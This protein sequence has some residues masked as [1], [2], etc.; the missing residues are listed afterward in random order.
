MP[1]NYGRPT[2]LVAA[3]SLEG[4]G[5]AMT[6]EGAFNTPAFVA[7]VEKLL[8]PSL[9]P[10]QIV[11]LDNLSVHKA[12]RIRELIEARGCQ[13]LFLPAYSPDFSPIEPCFSKIKEALRSVGARTQ[14]ALEEAIG[15]AIKQV[16]SEDA[17][18]WFRHCGFLA[19]SS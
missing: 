5:E 15:E 17:H 16:T 19:R 12:K 13:L 18:G 4:F 14:E 11:V 8:A 9:K 7:Y 3:L 1:R 10:D 6:L 2:S